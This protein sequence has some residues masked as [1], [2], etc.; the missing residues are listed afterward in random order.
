RNPVTHWL[1]ALPILARPEAR[2]L[3]LVGFGGGVAIEVVPPSIERI[4]VVE[5]EPEVIAA[6]RLVANGRW[7]DPLSDP[8]V[9]VH[10]NDARS[11]LSL[12]ASRFDVIVSQPSHPWAGGAAHLYTREFFELVRSRLAANGAFLQWIGLAFVDEA[13]FRSLLATLLDVFPH[14]RVYAPPPYGSILFLA[15]AEPFD[16]EHSV[17][18]ALAANPEPFGEL[19][20]RVPEDVTA[21]LLLD[22]AA[23]V[24]LARSAPLNQDGHN[25]LASRSD[26]LGDRALVK[27]IDDLLAPIDPLVRALPQGSDPFDIVRRLS[28]ARAERVAKALSDPVQRAVGE[29][30]AGIDDGKRE[31]PRRRLEEALRLDPRNQEARAAMLRLSV[32]AIAGGANPEQIVSPPLSDEERALADGWATR[33]RDPR[34]LAAGELDA[35]LAAVAPR[36]PLGPDAMRLRVQG[37]LASGDPGL[38]KDADLLANDYFGHRSDPSSILLLAETAAAVG[39]PA[40]V[41][42]R[43]SELIDALDPRRASSRAFAYRARDLA[44][45]TAADDPELS[46]MRAAVLRRLGVTVARGAPRNAGAG[47]R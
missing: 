7:R 43:L 22:E 31:R 30:I 18:R 28:G 23:V 46:W 12:A 15:S 20:I 8:R 3:L 5:L 11:A 47:K 39:D 13:L 26:R 10:L 4:D 40:T 14:V 38:A 25:R 21:D 16:M 41:L 37:R 17:A 34:A 44:R 6:N 32:G 45:A 2:S 35:R 24:E 29:A 27:T 33:A 1:T 42:E 9:H 19:G 36:H